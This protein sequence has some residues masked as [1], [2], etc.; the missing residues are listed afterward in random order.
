MIPGEELFVD[1]LP[2][3]QGVV[4]VDNLKDRTHLAFGV[5]VIELE[6]LGQPAEDDQPAAALRW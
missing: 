3:Q 1:K 4:R 6:A 5:F 2:T